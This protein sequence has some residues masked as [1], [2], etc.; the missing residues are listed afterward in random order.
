MVF[1]NFQPPIRLPHW[2]HLPERQNSHWPH[3]VIAPNQDT[4]ACLIAGDSRPDLFNDSYRFM[5]NRQ[6]RLYRILT[7]Q[8]MK[9]DSTDRR[10]SYA[11]Q[12]LVVSR[13]RNLFQFDGD[14]IH[15]FKDVC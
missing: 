5:T 13:L 7:F 12:S 8:N 9:I 6:P 3:G 15:T 4:L 1:P 14:S 2:A 11:Y 10:Q